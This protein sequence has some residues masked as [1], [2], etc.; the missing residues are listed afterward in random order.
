M[1]NNEFPNFAEWKEQFLIQ[2][3]NEKPVEMSNK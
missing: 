3:K 2:H 1:T